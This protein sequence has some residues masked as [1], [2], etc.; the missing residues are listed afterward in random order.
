[1]IVL[2][3]VLSCLYIFETLVVYSNITFIV[4]LKDCD[5]CM[6]YSIFRYHQST[7]FPISLHSLR[8][9]ERRVGK[10]IE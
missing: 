2:L 5:V 4:S 9:I 6:T 3:D 8:E 10:L 7:K 1:M